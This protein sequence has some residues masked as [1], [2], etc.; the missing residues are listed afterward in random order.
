MRYGDVSATL[1]NGSDLRSGYDY[2]STTLANG[3]RS[4]YG[5]GYTILTDGDCLMNKHGDGSATMANGSDLR[6]GYGDGS[7]YDSATLAA[8]CNLTQLSSITLEHYATRK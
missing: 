1:A 6:S 5:D 8:L 7:G 2:G 3:F 4:G